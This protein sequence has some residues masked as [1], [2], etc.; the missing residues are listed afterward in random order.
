MATYESPVAQEK[1]FQFRNLAMCQ[2]TAVGARGGER[3]L[4]RGGAFGRRKFIPVRFT[5]TCTKIKTERWNTVSSVS[6]QQ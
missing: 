6:V 1:S 2:M 3:T 5:Y 4:G